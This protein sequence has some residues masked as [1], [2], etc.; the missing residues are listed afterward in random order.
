MTTTIITQDMQGQNNSHITPLS[1]PSQDRYARKFSEYNQYNY[2]SSTS[3][4]HK[5][6]SDGAFHKLHPTNSPI[7]NK[8]I[9]YIIIV[10]FVSMFYNNTANGIKVH[11]T[12][13]WRK[14]HVHEDQFPPPTL[15]IEIHADTINLQIESFFMQ[16]FIFCIRTVLFPKTKV[17]L[18]FQTDVYFSTQKMCYLVF[19]CENEQFCAR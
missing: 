15:L 17:M 18:S 2:Q 12:R 5:S 6:I 9:K 4:P 1:P 19:V 8:K 3:F 14:R 16:S 13:I 10:Q 11:S 7:A